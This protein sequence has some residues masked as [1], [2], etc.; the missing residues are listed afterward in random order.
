G[1]GNLPFLRVANVDQFIDYQSAVTIPERLC[2]KYPTLAQVRKGDILF[3]K[4]GSVA[5]IGLMA[6][7]AAVSRDLIFLNSS[8]LSEPEYLFLFVYFQASFFN[9]SVVRS[10]SQTAQPHLTITLVRELPISLPTVVFR[11]AVTA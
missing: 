7:H 10:S 3:T 5:R 6:Q 1:T 8:S 11:V 2:E 9:R 4:G